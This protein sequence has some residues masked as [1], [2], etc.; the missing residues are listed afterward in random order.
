M[1]HFSKLGFSLLLSLLLCIPSALAVFYYATPM[2]DVVYSSTA[3]AMTEKNGREITAGAF[4][5]MKTEP[6]QS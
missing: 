2:K 1:K 3:L 5:Q 4:I 6:G